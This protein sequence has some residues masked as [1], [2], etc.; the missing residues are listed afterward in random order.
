MAF[1]LTDT[2]R[3][4]SQQ[5]N[6]GQQIIVEIEGIDL[7]FSAVQISRFWEIGDDVNIGDSGLVIGGIIDNENSRSYL[8]L[9][10]TTNNITQQLEIDKGGVSSVQKFNVALID[11]DEELT[12]L[13]QPGNVV[14]DLLGLEANVYVGFAGGA[15]PD[16][17][18]RIFNGIITAQSAEPGVWKLT[19]DFPEFLKRQDLYDQISTNL[20]GAITNSATSL[21]VNSSVGFIPP[22]DSQDSYLLV[23][24]ELMKWSSVNTSTNT[25][26]IT[27]RGA[28]G[29]V[30]VSHD[31]D[32]QVTSFYTLS[33]GG[34]DLALKLMLSNE[35]NV[36]FSDSNPAT[37]FEFVNNSLIV[38][39]GIL[40][41]SGLRDELG[42]ELGDLVSISGATEPAN[43]ITDAPIVQFQDI[44][45]GL[46][47]VVSGV[48]LAQEVDSPAVASFKSQYNVLAE[49]CGMKPSQVD[50]AQFQS[51]QEFYSSLPDYLIYL[52][53]TIN[54]QDFIR[55][56]LF[57]PQG[58]YN[59]PRKG[60]VSANATQPPLVLSDLVELNENNVKKAQNNKIKRQIT[61]NFFNAV[62]YRFDLDSITDRLLAGEIVVSER[63][64]NRIPTGNK[65]L[66]ITA[67]GLRDSN[68]VRNFISAQTRR[69]IDRYQF[70]AESITVEVNYKTGFNIEVSDIVNFG[71]AELQLP[72]IKNGTRDFEPRLMEVVNKSMN[73]KN[74]QVKLE[75]LDTGFSADDG[76][77]GVVSPNSFVGSGATN[78]TIPLKRSFSTTLFENERDKWTTFLGQEI[79]VRDQDFI[80]NETVTLLNFDAGNDANII[81]DPPLSLPPQEDY[82]IDLPNY[83]TVLND[84]QSKMKPIHCF[85]NPTVTVISGASDTEFTVSVADAG[86]LFEGAFIRVHNDDFTD[87]STPGSSDDDV[88]IVSVDA[89]TGE[90]VVDKSMGFT[91]SSGYIVDLIG[92]F[93][94]NGSPYRF[95]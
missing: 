83:D 66:K 76:R 14:T 75:L 25:F 67:G 91:P 1:E 33:G 57:L 29:T 20:D 21:V 90:V 22:A 52:K 4:L 92:F 50:V 77:F 15:H 55:Q 6:I 19:I 89:G 84:S 79:R 68:D 64:N 38:E 8:S 34:L 46:I 5:T 81:V 40:F 13:F 61:K 39:N 27:E 10:G 86:F 28:L 82:V 7:S 69:F 80:F 18:V 71:S 2:A 53:D 51:L 62:S 88:V 70:A 49:G 41:E 94:D 74:G 45:Q 17:S 78:N 87:N 43:N 42:L 9:S 36:A 44:P 95:V 54:A 85:M 63:S 35:G 23:N 24:E 37:R 48:T 65:T 72:D 16:D 59:V 60:R 12:A 56:E 73:L 32:A 11:K 93:P 47:V 30:A 31:D 3:L 58:F 26:T